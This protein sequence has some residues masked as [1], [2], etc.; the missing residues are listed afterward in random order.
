MQNPTSTLPVL[1]MMGGI[2][3]IKDP[4]LVSLISVPSCRMSASIVL[5]AKMKSYW[6][7]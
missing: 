6:S 1:P 3:Y 4:F 5:N 7:S 2:A